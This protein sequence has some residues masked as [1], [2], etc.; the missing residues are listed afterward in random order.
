MHATQI[1]IVSQTLRELIVVDPPYS[2]LSGIFAIIGLLA[3]A[4]GFFLMYFLRVGFS[5]PLRV[6]AWLIPILIA[7]PFIIVALFTGATTRITV[8][9][10][11]GTLSARKTILSVPLRSRE[12]PLVE[13]RLVNVGVGNVC[14]FLYVSLDGKQAEDLTGCTD[15]TGYSETADTIN[16]FLSAHRR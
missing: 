12:Y 3:L 5:R 7:S 13:V 8:S 10:D 6:F 14:R 1:H 2:L 4:G 16:A 9:V 15:R 11:T